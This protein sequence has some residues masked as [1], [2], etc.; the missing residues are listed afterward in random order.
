VNKT[1]L[2]HTERERKLENR[3]GNIVE[4]NSVEDIDVNG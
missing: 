3:V 2:I 1:R 4:R